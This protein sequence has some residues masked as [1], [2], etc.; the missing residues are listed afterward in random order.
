MVSLFGKETALEKAFATTLLPSWIAN[1]GYQITERM[2]AAKLDGRERVRSLTAGAAQA[3]LEEVKHYQ[4]CM[5]EIQE[6]GRGAI[7]RAIL[8]AAQEFPREHTVN[9][10]AKVALKHF[11]TGNPNANLRLEAMVGRC[12]LD[13]LE[14]ARLPKLD[15]SKDL[16]PYFNNNPYAHEQGDIEYLTIIRPLFDCRRQYINRKREVRLDWDAVSALSEKYDE[17]PAIDHPKYKWIFSKP[18]LGIW[19]EL[20]Q[21]S[22][23]RH[24]EAFETYLS[25]DFYGYELQEVVE[26]AIV[27][28]AKEFNRPLKN[29][30]SVKLWTIVEGLALYLCQ[31]NLMPWYLIDDSTRVADTMHLVGLALPAALNRLEHDGL[32]RPGSPVKNLALVLSMFFHWAQ[33]SPYSNLLRCASSD[34]ADAWLGVAALYARKH[35]IDIEGEGVYNIREMTMKAPYDCPAGNIDIR[36][37]RLVN[38]KYRADKFR[39]RGQ[40][41]GKCCDGQD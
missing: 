13:E 19:K 23:N 15:P 7:N 14:N 8:K 31:E 6:A 20:C 38:A 30:D 39:F 32:L 40:V 9:Y 11:S 3:I 12:I 10:L 1:Q 24:P 27:W 21:Q 26:N 35:N 5:N 34:G 33:D 4:K 25:T 28:F 22:E 36:Q 2:K 41:R 16:S 37:E 18:A 17:K 29:R